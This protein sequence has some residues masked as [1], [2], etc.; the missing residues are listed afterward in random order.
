[1]NAL[2]LARVRSSEMALIKYSHSETFSALKNVQEKIDKNLTSYQYLTVF[3]DLVLSAIAP[4]VENTKFFEIYLSQIIGWQTL[5]SKRKTC[6]VGRHKLVALYTLLL[7]TGDIRQKMKLIKKMKLHK[8]ILME[9]VRRW[10]KILD[11]YP[12]TASSLGTLE[13]VNKLYELNERALMRPG[14][15]LHS[16]YTTVSY[17]YHQADSFKNKIIEKYTRMIAN[18]AQKD[19]VDLE[20]SIP[21]DDIIQIY[22]LTGS[23]A[24]DKCDADRGVLT[25]YIKN[26][27]K[28]AK[29]VAQASNS[30]NSVQAIRFGSKVVGAV[31]NQVDL[32]DIQ[33]STDDE[34]SKERVS[35]IERVRYVA[36]LFD[37]LGYGRIAL[38]IQEQLSTEHLQTLRS[39]AVPVE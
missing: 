29:N 20:H 31:V 7:L 27:L 11:E 21:L 10:T 33:T 14:F 2:L 22:M 6:G 17:W 38:G 25:T 16:T 3:E 1:M 32:E 26:W 19:Y 4:I 15:A 8:N 39:L 9:C 5:N 36:K 24:I 12:Q 37:P 13:V 35:E 23:K 28:S 18:T 30:Q 34:D